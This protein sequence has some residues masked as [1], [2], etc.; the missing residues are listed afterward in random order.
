MKVANFTFVLRYFGIH[1]F[2]RQF[3]AISRKYNSAL[4]RFITQDKQ[5]VSHYQSISEAS[6]VHCL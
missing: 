2:W 5:K 1:I 4:T 6:L 3:K